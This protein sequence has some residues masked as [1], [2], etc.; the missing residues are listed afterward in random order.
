MEQPSAGV[1][2]ESPNYR[3]GEPLR[4]W[5]SSELVTATDAELIIQNA[6]A[7]PAIVRLV[8]GEPISV[9]DELTFGRLNWWCVQ[10]WYEPMVMLIRRQ[11]IH[12]ALPELL[13]N[14]TKVF[15]D[16]R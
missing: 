2:G 16:P 11:Q 7:G 5:D 3:P 14:H 9:E 15:R 1:T 10:M 8:N 13:R 4:S 6:E 12:P